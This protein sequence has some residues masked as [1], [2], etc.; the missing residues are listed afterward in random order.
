MTIFFVLF[1]YFGI[2]GGISFL[3][4]RWSA[5]T[6]VRKTQIKRPTLKSSN[7]SPQKD[8]ENIRRDWDKIL[9]IQ[10]SSRK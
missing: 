4:G 6:A 8:A 5:D 1:L 2:V 9:G 10:R 7:N 3:L